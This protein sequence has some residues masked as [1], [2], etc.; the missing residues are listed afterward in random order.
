MNLRHAV[1][2]TV[3]RDD[4]K[5]GGAAHIAKTIRAIHEINPGTTV[6]ILVSD[7]SRDRDAIRTALDARPEV[8]CHNIE[9]VERLYPRV[10][11]R[12][13]SYTGALSVLRMASEE[14]H[15]AI[16]KSALM[17]GHGE[18]PAEVESTLRD[19][20][21]AGCEAVCVGQ[22]LRPS[23]KQ[24]AVAEFVRPDRFARYEALAYELGFEFAVAGPF[25]RSSYRSEALLETP[26]AQRRLGL[27]PSVVALGQ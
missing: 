12:R 17:V 5:D 27:R 16:V 1:V 23:G 10:R 4:L 7:F 21:E 9:T 18:T 25:V 3:V 20:R 6:E 26:F 11:D 14:S 8:F 15:G 24:I 19:L 2:T 13:F 22:Y